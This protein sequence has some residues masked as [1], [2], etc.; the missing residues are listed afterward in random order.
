[1]ILASFPI[2]IATNPIEPESVWENADVELSQL[3][4]DTSCDGFIGETI[5]SIDDPYM[6]IDGVAYEVAQVGGLRPTFEDGEVMLPVSI[7]IERTGG[8]LEV[9]T[10][11]QRIT[12]EYD[13]IIEMT[14]DEFVV[15]VNGLPQSMNVAPK[16]VD[17]ALM[18][19]L[20][21]LEEF[22][23]FEVYW[24]P[25]AQQ[26]RLTRD[27]QTRRLI[28][29]MDTEYDLSDIGATTT[30]R[31]SDDAVF[32]QFETIQE[33][34]VA[35]GLLSE[36]DVVTWVEPNLITVIPHTDIDLEAL[37]TGPS[38]WNAER[39]G[40]VDYANFVRNIDREVIVAVIDTGVNIYHPI[41]EYEDE[42]GNVGTRIVNPRC[43]AT[44]G[45]GTDVT[46]YVNHGTPVAGVVVTNTYG[47]NNVRIMP[48]RVSLTRVVDLNAIASGIDFAVRNGADVINVS[49]HLPTDRYSTRLA[50]A[51]D[52]AIDN[53]VIMV[54]IAGNQ[55]R[56]L[57]DFG[58]Y[59]TPQG[60]IRIA[61][62]DRWD[63]P[64]ISSN[65][66]SSGLLVQLAAPGTNI[67]N[68]HANGGHGTIAGTSFAAPHVAAAVAMYRLANP[69]LTVEE[70]QHN[71]MYYYVD[72][73]DGWERRFGTGI[74]DM[75]RA[76]PPTVFFNF[77]GIGSM[78][79]VAVPI[80]F[81][82]S[83]DMTEVTSVMEE[84]E[85]RYPRIASDFA[86]WGWFIADVLNESGRLSTLS[87]VNQNQR[88]RRPDIGKSG[89]DTSQV[90]TQEVLN[91]YAR[92]GVIHLYSIWSL[93][94]DVNDDGIVNPV[95]ANLLF[96]HAG[97]I[98]GA[99]VIN[100]AP[101]DVVRDYEVTP[102]DANV[103]FQH[104]GH[105][106]GAPT[107]GQRPGLARAF[108]ESSATWRLSY[109]AV[110][111]TSTTMSVR[112]ELYQNSDRG[113]GLTFLTLHYDSSILSNPRAIQVWRLDFDAIASNPD[114]Q[115]LYD[116]RSG[117]GWTHDQMANH[118]QFA[119]V[120][121]DAS[122]YSNDFMFDYVLYPGHLHGS[123]VILL[124][125]NNARMTT[126]YFGSDIFVYITFDVASGAQVAET[127]AV[128]FND[129]FQYMTWAVGAG[130]NTLILKD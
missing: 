125:W 63:D 4:Y 39:V 86:F 121:Y 21:T 77:Y 26:I 5:F 15:N 98:Y 106:Y 32:L 66:S 89:F 40:T 42:C 99:P 48:I 90:I 33:T 34:Q 75:R 14:A 25:D 49:T 30:I 38:T 92:D 68:A 130:S 13:S 71:I 52:Y 123:D 116:W 105:V 87:N 11:T 104:V 16:I 58:H 17:G 53:G 20:C 112:V 76:I 24:E 23:G 97:H 29:R 85:A 7:L 107:L 111:P 56:N 127:G 79:P 96:Q 103:L 18:L 122:S 31:T 126:P 54:G 119:S 65:F 8:S 88:L 50:E 72:E 61:A 46:D 22:F 55:E 84:L 95:D 28:L 59:N 57:D 73:P 37:N 110:A 10:L 62:T 12:I 69:Y 64:W 70:M 91:S 100:L 45:G 108:T 93:W 128:R 114:M 82:Q 35:Y 9:D 74:L 2:A 67:T 44:F 60:V 83:L 120:R 113:M 124:R 1:M 129:G 47:L 94:G 117:Q 27:F 36:L 118:A 102:I 43:L 101:A 41:F 51:I 81:G 78:R 6:W 19:S 109:E 115:E 80:E 3:I